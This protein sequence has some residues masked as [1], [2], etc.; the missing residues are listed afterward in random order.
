[1]AV[2]RPLLPASDE[3]LI[4][5][6]YSFTG[7]KFTGLHVIYALRAVTAKWQRKAVE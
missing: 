6:Q 1:V 7:G 4:N 5:F 2:R 3:C